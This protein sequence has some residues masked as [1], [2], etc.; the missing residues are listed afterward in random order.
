MSGQR[1]VAALM[2]FV[3]FG[4]VGYFLGQYKPFTGGFLVEIAEPFS[5]AR[6]QVALGY[7]IV[8]GILGGDNWATGQPK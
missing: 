3:I 6:N 2:M 7:F 1:I 4:A 5:P 8:G